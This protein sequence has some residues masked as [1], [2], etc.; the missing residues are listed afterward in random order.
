MEKDLKSYLDQQFSDIRKKLTEHDQ[1]FVKIDR[2]FTKIDEQFIKIDERFDA[3]IEAVNS[4][5]KDFD[6][7]KHDIAVIKDNIREKL[8]VDV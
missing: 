8:G 6:G 2:R 1:Q 3:L 5:A 7:V 4:G